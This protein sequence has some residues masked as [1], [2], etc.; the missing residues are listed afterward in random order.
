[1]KITF[2]HNSPKL[3]DAIIIGGLTLREILDIENMPSE[4]VDNKVLNYLNEEGDITDK[5]SKESLSV[6]ITFFSNKAHYK[7]R[8]FLDNAHMAALIGVEKL[9]P[10]KSEVVEFFLK[11][12][13]EHKDTLIGVSAAYGLVKAITKK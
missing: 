8:L 11:L 10:K 3:D 2:N 9:N 12:N 6:L 5:L 1:M 4:E 7:G 13:E